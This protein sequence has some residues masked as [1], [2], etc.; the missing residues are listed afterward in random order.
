MRNLRFF[1]VVMLMITLSNCTEKKEKKDNTDLDSIENFAETDTIVYSS[2]NF[3]AMEL[4]NIAPDE[5]YEIHDYHDLIELFQQLNYTPEAWSQGIRQV[6]RMYL[7]SIG[8]RWGAQ[9]TREITVLQ[10]KQLFFHALAPLVLRSNELIL[11]DRQRLEAL[12]KNSSPENELNGNDEI[13]I[14]KLVALYKI[15]GTSETMLSTLHDLLERVDIIPASLALGQAAEE[16]GWGTSR[17]VSAGN[18]LY[19][20]WTWGKNAIVPEQQRKELGNYGIAAFESLYASVSSY[21][22]NINTHNAYADLRNKRAELRSSGAAI[23]GSVLAGQLTKYSERGEE[24]V[25]GLKS[26]MDYN[27]LH[28]VDSAYLADGNTIFLIPAAADPS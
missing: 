16:S 22:L 21:M 5:K 20:Q 19:G 27:H 13:F 9:T 26:L 3:A 17:F 15:N 23:S 1:L 24:Y 10:K 25:K 8:H 14:S 18:A 11:R 4:E 12:I 28:P 2:P 6:P 7:T